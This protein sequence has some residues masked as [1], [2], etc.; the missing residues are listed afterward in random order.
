MKGKKRSKWSPSST[1][2]RQPRTEPKTPSKTHSV[3]ALH[4]RFTRV[5]AQLLYSYYSATGVKISEATVFSSPS[6]RTVRIIA[7]EREGAQL[8]LAIAN[9]SDETVTYTIEVTNATNLGTMT[10]S[11]HTSIARFLN[12]LVP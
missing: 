11:P 10:L 4:T 9:D 2:K 8:G 3:N 7:D 6:A 1:S 12:Q 5:E